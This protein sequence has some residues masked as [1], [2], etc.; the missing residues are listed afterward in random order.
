MILMFCFAMTYASK[1]Q[2]IIREDEEFLKVAQKVRIEKIAMEKRII[3]N[4]MRE[5]LVF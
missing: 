1:I 2:S 4:Q 5:M 3:K